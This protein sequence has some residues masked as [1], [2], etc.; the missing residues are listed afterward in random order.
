MPLLEVRNLSKK[1][2]GKTILSDINFA[3]EEGEFLLIAGKNGSGKTVT[4]LHLGGLVKPSEGE[5]YFE[6]KKLGIN[7]EA[8]KKIGLVFQEANTQIFCQTVM[9]EVSFAIKQSKEPNPEQSAEEILKKMD[10]YHLKDR[11]PFH[12]SG[13]QLKKVT[14]ASILAQ[15][16]KI[17]IL[18]EPFI[19]LDYP[20]VQMIL[21]TLVDLHNQG[22]T[23]IVIS[24][25]LDKVLYHATRLMIIHD[26]TVVYDGDKLQAMD[27]LQGWGIKRPHNPQ[28]ASWLL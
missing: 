9:E 12:L 1:I 2:D 25:D 17:L 28:K 18:D 3:V 8:K 16:P 26:G 24:H 23:I 21:Q 22:I 13:G 11:S 15:K 19:G 4:M 5:I 6:N 10:I 14:I 7:K 20:G 27:K